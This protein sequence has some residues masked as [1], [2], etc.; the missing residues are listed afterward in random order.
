M[1]TSARIGKLDQIKRSSGALLMTLC[2]MALSS[3]SALAQSTETLRPPRVADP[4]S[5]PKVMVFL[6]VVL[7]TG[8]VI[9]A[10]TLKSK[11]GH[12]D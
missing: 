7:L 11:R 2:M 10:A 4:P 12:Q 5:A 9:F 6:L 8:A 3:S 1:M